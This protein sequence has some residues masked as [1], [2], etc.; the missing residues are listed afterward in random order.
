MQDTRNTHRYLATLLL[1][2]G[3]LVLVLV[4]MIVAFGI[5]NPRFFRLSSLQTLL[6][7]VPDKAIVAVGMTF[8]IMTA[9]IDLSVGSVLGLSAAAMAA[10][11]IHPSV[12]QPMLAGIVACLGTGLACGAVN[13][14]LTVRWRLPSFIVTLGMLEMARGGAYIATDSRTLYL[15]D[16]AAAKPLM[17]FVS[18]RFLGIP[19]SVYIAVAV[20]AVAHIVLTRTVFGRYVTAVGTNEEA[21]RLSGIDVRKVRFAVFAISGLLV[22]LGALVNTARLG[23]VTP[24]AGEGWELQAIAAVVIGGTS[25]M[26]GRGSVLKTV[27]GVLIMAVLASGLSFVGASEYHKR[28]I[29]GGVIV[30]AVIAD[31]YR[32]RLV[33]G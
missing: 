10:V 26:G 29:T 9:G 11:T 27:L 23:S 8:V 13:G 14:F 22:G 18:G 28:I 20:I 21:V 19:V 7:Q 3:V 6:T 4:A 31:Y 25:L 24:G 12:P 30:A 33:R 17:T 16:K 5:G 2:Y 15:A 32:L 1:E